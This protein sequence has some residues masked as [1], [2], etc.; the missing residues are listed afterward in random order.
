MTSQPTKTLARRLRTLAFHIDFLYDYIK[1]HSDHKHADLQVVTGADGA[2]TVVNKRTMTAQPVM[3]AQGRTAQGKT[4]AAKALTESQA[5]S[6]LFGARMYESN[7]IL[8]E[9]EKAGVTRPGAIK[10]SAETV[11]RILGLGTD[12]MGGT[13]ADAAGTLTNWTQSKSQ[14]RVDQARRDF[15]N[16]VLRK[17]SGAV[18]SSQEFANADKQYF[19]QPGD[20]KAAIEQK[21]NNRELAMN[22]MLKEVP[23]AQRYRP[24][25]SPA[26]STAPA[27]ADFGTGETTPAADGWSI[28]RI[29]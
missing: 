26:V 6:N 1:N 23:D 7:N 29:D 17:E 25:A 8:N 15:V 13:L 28:R 18:I 12:S 9:L 20:T 24:G 22:M 5:K 14:Q 16:A 4:V 27:Q 2:I 10:G 21:R 3:D 11:G 19:P